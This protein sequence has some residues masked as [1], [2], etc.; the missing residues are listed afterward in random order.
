MAFFG[1]GQGKERSAQFGVVVLIRHH[2]VKVKS[3]IFDLQGQFHQV[4]A[5]I[6]TTVRQFCQNILDRLA[7]LDD[8]SLECFKSLVKGRYI[9]PVLPP[10]FV[11][12]VRM[13]RFG[14]RKLLEC[15]QRDLF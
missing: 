13:C 11:N 14:C 8:I 10:F 1:L 4:E 6:V 12:R 7:T 2:P 5:G 3:C 9:G 15:L